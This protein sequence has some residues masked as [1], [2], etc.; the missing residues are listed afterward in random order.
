MSREGVATR[1][2]A[3]G[4]AW[5]PSQNGHAHTLPTANSSSLCRSQ[6]LLPGAKFRTAATLDPEQS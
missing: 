3:P 1:R 5:C 2:R 6:D 4:M